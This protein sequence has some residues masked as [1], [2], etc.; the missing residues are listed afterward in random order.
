VLCVLIHWL[1]VDTVLVC[2]VVVGGS[3]LGLCWVVCMAQKLVCVAQVLACVWHRSMYVW[4]RS[5]CVL[6]KLL[7]CMAQV[8]V[9]GTGVWATQICEAANLLAGEASESDRGLP[10]F[11]WQGEASK[12]STRCRMRRFG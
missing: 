7:V 11:P 8:F 2:V 9:C 12:V 10:V 5:L 4:C 1:C 6:Q 3:A